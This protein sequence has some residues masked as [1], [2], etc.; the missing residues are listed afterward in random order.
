MTSFASFLTTDDSA[1]QSW[2]SRTQ[3]STGSIRRTEYRFFDRRRLGKV[4][5]SNK[6]N[7][8][9]VFERTQGML[10]EITFDHWP[11]TLLKNND[12]VIYVFK[13]MFK[14]RGV[15]VLVICDTSQETVSYVSQAHLEILSNR[16]GTFW[17]DLSHFVLCFTFI[18]MCM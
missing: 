7:I 8:D 2:N 13:A 15:V 3:E 17:C 12:R 1:T 5:V 10:A 14:N 18:R 11:W 16:H 6:Q 9:C 4:R